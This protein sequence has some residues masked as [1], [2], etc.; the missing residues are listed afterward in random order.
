MRVVNATDELVASTTAY[1]D[2]RGLVMLHVLIC[3]QFVP[4]MAVR[5]LCVFL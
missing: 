4:S 5:V 2:A 1:L 3:K